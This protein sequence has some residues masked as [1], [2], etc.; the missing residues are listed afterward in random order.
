MQN[1]IKTSEELQQIL[2][3]ARVQQISNSYIIPTEVEKLFEVSIDHAPAIIQTL[4]AIGGSEALMQAKA[5]NEIRR[6]VHW[7]QRRYGVS[8]LTKSVFEARDR[9]LEYLDWDE[10]LCLLPGDFQKLE[11]QV[12]IVLE[13]FL[14]VSTGY[15]LFLDEDD[16]RI[17]IEE[18]A[19]RR[20]A[21]AASWAWIRKESHDWV[22][23]PNEPDTFRG[24]PVERHEPD[25]ITI[26]MAIG[27]PDDSK[28]DRIYILAVHP[29]DSRRPFRN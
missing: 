8:G 27:N 2:I 14:D 18:P 7:Y 29:D 24:I 16:D 22:P 26:G 23:L 28:C 21:L 15:H 10:D 3:D 9:T 20:H 25:E 12:P 13:A 17:P 6:Q 5:I 11:S 19:I 4:Y 1:Q